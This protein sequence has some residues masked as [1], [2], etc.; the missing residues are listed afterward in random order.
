MKTSEFLTKARQLIRRGWTQG[1]PAKDE[2]GCPADPS[3]PEAC[4]WCSIGSLWKVSSISPL[5]VRDPMGFLETAIRMGGFKQQYLIDFNEHP[6]R[7]KAQVLS[8]FD[9]AIKLAKAKERRAD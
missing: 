1:P 3:A 9:R 8:V 6:G 2:Q 5:G 4:Q 7:T